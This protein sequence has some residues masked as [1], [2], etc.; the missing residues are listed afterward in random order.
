MSSGRAVDQRA[1]PERRTPQVPR[2]TARPAGLRRGAVGVA[3]TVVA[4]AV[5]LTVTTRGPASPGTD[6]AA[7]T[8]ER[9]HPQVI[10]VAGAGIV[11]HTARTL[12]WAYSVALWPLTVVTLLWLAR[13][14]QAVYMRTS[15]ALLMS[16]AAGGG[17]C[18]AIRGRPGY[19]GAIAHEYPA[20]AGVRAGWYLLLAL[21][22]LATAGRPRW[23]AVLRST[24]PGV[25][26]IPFLATDL[27]PLTALTAVGM[28]L[29]AWYVAG[30]ARRRRGT[31]RGPAA[32]PSLRRAG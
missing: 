4:Y 3:A 24:A 11:T 27:P 20:V 16:G 10:A 5:L 6:W 12:S 25:A 31:A 2:A 1:G 22:V 26:V 30:Y 28:P 7:S 17:L 19:A 14:H 13:R 15:A 9:L 29:L 18:L 21:A 23:A 32:A 8:A